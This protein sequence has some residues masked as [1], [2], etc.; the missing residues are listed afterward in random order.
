LWRIFATFPLWRGY[1][2]AV[3]FLAGLVFAAAV[4]SKAFAEGPVPNR[5]PLAPNVFY[6]L[7]LGSVKPAGWIRQQLRIQADG[8]SGHL[9]EFWP[10]VG[11]DS[12]WLGGSGE[13]WERGPYYLDGLVPLAYLLDD[14]VLIAKARKWIDW[15]LEHQRPDGAIGPEKNSDWWPNMVMLKALTQYQEVT[16]DARVIPVLEK[17]FDYQARQLAANPLQKWAQYRWGDEALSI[18]WLYNRNG[19]AKLLDLARQLSRQ[20]FD[21]K[22]LFA[23]YPYKEKVAKKDAGLASHGVNNAMAMKTEA[24]WSLISDN[25]EDR[26]ASRH[27]IE[28]LD[29]YHGLP[30]GVF[31]ADEHLAGHDPSQGTELC[32]VVEEMFSLEELVQIYGDAQLAGR[33]EQVAYNALPGAFSKDMWAHQYD[34]QPNQVLV[35]NA[36]RDWTTNGPQSNLFGLEPNFGC[37]TANMHQGWPKFAASLWMG[38]ADHGLAAIGYAPADVRTAVNGTPVHVA[39]ETIYPFGDEVSIKVDPSQPVTFPLKLRIPRWTSGAV[40]RINGVA[41]RGVQ[42]GVF[43]TL[44]REWHAG[45]TVFMRLP[46]PVIVSHTPQGAV[47]VDRGPLVYSLAIGEKWKKLA[48]KGE[49]ADW[50]VEPSTRWNYAL[51]VNAKDPQSSF[52]I[53]VRPMGNQPFSRQGT[54]VKLHARGVLLK[55]WKLVDNSAGPLPASPVKASGPG[56]EITLIPYGAAK[57]RITEFPEV[58]SQVQR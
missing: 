41:Q 30:G 26:T 51:V 22:G 25:P 44:P 24:L 1:D 40:V 14:P 8:L 13:G 39:V 55:S 58:Q 48:D 23:D 50:E 7:P 56:D 29:R 16:G 10:D 52:R 54:P 47:F 27:M 57:L 15:T 17:Y 20:G 35:S 34:Q 33:L 9:D 2:E 53:E 43:L 45:D 38:T 28:Q 11:T 32:A 46:M 31:A 19:G 18:V 12:A 3:K 6:S 49:T 5:A 37:C 36:P 42:P 4:V 21:W